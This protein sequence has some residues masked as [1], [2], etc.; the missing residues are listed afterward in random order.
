ME[1]RRLKQLIAEEMMLALTEAQAD[2]INHTKA[3]NVH[4][5]L[6]LGSCIAEY[7]K[8]RM[9]ERRFREAI[10]SRMIDREDVYAPATRS[11]LT[12]DLVTRTA[13]IVSAEIRADIEEMVEDIIKQLMI[14]W[15]LW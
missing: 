7:L 11:G 3:N 13:N 4:I 8:K 10:V 6:S 2:V 14:S 12:K 1:K 9:K 15:K 5:D